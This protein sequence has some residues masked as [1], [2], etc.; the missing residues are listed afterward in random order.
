MTTAAYKLPDY[1]KRILR[2]EKLSANFP[3]AGEAL[4]FYERIAQFQKELCT[5]FAKGW[6][7]QPIAPP[8]GYLR[9]ELNFIALLPHY[10]N[11]LAI[12]ELRAP[13]PLAAAA[14]MLARQGSAAWTALLSDYWANGGMA[15][16]DSVSRQGDGRDPLQEFLAHGFMQPY[17]EFVAAH[18]E[19]PAT[20]STPYICPKC[21]SLPSLGILRVEG[22]GGKR[23]L[24]CA[25]CAYEWDFR[26]ILCPACGEER[27]ERLPVFVAEQFPHIRVESCETCKHYLRTIDLTKD[28]NAVPE[29][30]DLAAIPL[31]LWAQEHGYARIHPNLLGT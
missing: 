17:A 23:F 2:A 27:E 16:D 21:D 6:G 29:V 30:D 12:I 28:G 15:D 26:R 10:P 11:F 1:E 3:F 19:T 31:T 7:E 20:E 18:L 8:D 13:R 14:G 22:D 24:R 25:F 5:S 9:S 4:T